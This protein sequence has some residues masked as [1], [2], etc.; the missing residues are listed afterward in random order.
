M[1]KLLAFTAIF[2]CLA[3][4]T[5]CSDAP[6]Q[7]ALDHNDSDQVAEAYVRAVFARDGSHAA[8]ELTGLSPELQRYCNLGLAQDWR[9]EMP[10]DVTFVEAG[11]KTSKGKGPTEKYDDYLFAL[12]DEQGKGPFNSS[13]TITYIIELKFVDGDGKEHTA[14]VALRPDH[15]DQPL[16]KGKTFDWKD[17]EWKVVPR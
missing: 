14:D 2:T 5:G 15:G 11:Q 16:T 17:V 4:L 13:R 8:L 6:D 3:I 7:S 10:P 9:A 12:T 1:N